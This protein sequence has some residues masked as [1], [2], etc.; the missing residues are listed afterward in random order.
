MDTP[1]TKLFLNIE[2]LSDDGRIGCLFPER[3]CMYGKYLTIILV[4]TVALI[5]GGG[6][7]LTDHQS[8]FESTV[9][10]FRSSYGDIRESS[11]IDAGSVTWDGD[12]HILLSS[13]SSRYN[14]RTDREFTKELITSVNPAIKVD[15]NPSPKINK[16]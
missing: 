12:G 14:D 15:I 7:G 6:F 11:I 4:P 16:D 8:I 13:F 3:E 5:V 10:E 1:T 9:E 2:N